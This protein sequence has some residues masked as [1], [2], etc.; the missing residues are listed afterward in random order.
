[1][2]YNAI[3]S[4]GVVF[5][6][7][8]L[9]FCHNLLELNLSN[10]NITSDAVPAIALV[11]ENFCHL[12]ELYLRYNAIGID[13]AALLVAAWTH[14][15]LL[16][17]NLE[18]CVESSCESSLLKGEEHCS[19]CSRL[20]QLYQFNDNIIIKVSGGHVPKLISSARY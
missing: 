10:N 13:G 16:T 11:M 15:T 4:D 7:K 17:L 19:G 3:D 14:K 20:L 9:Q 5:L 1:M 18:D 2:T 6:S 8:R 12:K